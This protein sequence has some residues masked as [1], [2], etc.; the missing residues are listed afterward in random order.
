MEIFMRKHCRSHK[1]S[2]GKFVLS[3][4]TRMVRMFDYLQT[5]GGGWRGWS[6]QTVS[7]AKAEGQVGRGEAERIVRRDDDGVVKV[8]GY[9]RTQ[10]SQLARRSAT[11]LTYGTL[12]AVASYAGGDRLARWER[13]EVEKFVAWPLIGDTYAVAVRPAIGERQRKQAMALFRGERLAA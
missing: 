2:R 1:R 8:V 10:A 9:K 11:S 13:R 5:P 3:A 12:Q 6:F 4:A 7:Q